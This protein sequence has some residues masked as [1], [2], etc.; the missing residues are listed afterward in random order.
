[1]YKGICEGSNSI[2]GQSFRGAQMDRRLAIA[3]PLLPKQS[4]PYLCL[5]L[6]YC[7]FGPPLR[8]KE[9]FDFPVRHLVSRVSICILKYSKL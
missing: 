1:M 6:P 5:S 2:T 3:V 4:L 9:L 8:A 7:Y